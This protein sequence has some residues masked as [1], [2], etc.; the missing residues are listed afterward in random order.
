MFPTLP[1]TNF[2]SS[3]NFFFFSSTSAFNLDQSKNMSFGKEINTLSSS[4]QQI[5]TLPNSRLVTTI[6][7]LI[8]MNCSSLKRFKT[9]WKNE[10]ML[11]T[12][13]QTT[14][15]RLVQSI[16][17]V[18]HGSVVECLTGNPGV[19]GLSCSRSSCFSWE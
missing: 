11:L 4:K 15:S 7:S 16:C 8:H 18:H 1:K 3:V 9:V 17:G 5:W 13:Y 19:L 2:N 14:I 12:Y 6:L 10:I